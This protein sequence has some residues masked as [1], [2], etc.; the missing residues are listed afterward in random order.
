M[1]ALNYVQV[2]RFVLYCVMMSVGD[3]SFIARVSHVRTK[4]VDRCAFFE[5]FLVYCYH[6]VHVSQHVIAAVL[7]WCTPLLSQVQHAQDAGA[8]AVLVISEL[9]CVTY[10]LTHIAA[11]SVIAFTM[12]HSTHPTTQCSHTIHT[13]HC[14]LQS[15][16]PHTPLP[17]A[18]THSTHSTAHCSHT[19]HTHH[20]PLQSHTPHTLHTHSA[21][22]CLFWA[23]HVLCIMH[24]L[25]P[26]C[27]VVCSDH[28]C[29]CKWA[30]INIYCKCFY[31]Q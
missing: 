25:S 12:Q 31:M 22:V 2:C 29:T 8:K 14:P 1:G 4:H 5:V 23:A 13:P 26:H 27:L 18:V 21:H 17:T 15:H 28:V 3:A 9:T 6:T 16:T 24:T 19:L 11:V 20:C 7:H 10:N 30:D